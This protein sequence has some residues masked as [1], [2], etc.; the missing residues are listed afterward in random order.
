MR[1]RGKLLLKSKV[2]PNIRKTRPTASL[3]Q[4]SESQLYWASLEFLSF[5][6]SNFFSFP[7]SPQGGGCFLQLLPSGSLSFLFTLLVSKFTIFILLLNCVPTFL[8]PHGL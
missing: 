5:S 4:R 6:L 8:Q 7:L 1:P 3:P 2:P